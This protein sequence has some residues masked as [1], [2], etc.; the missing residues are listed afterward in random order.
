MVSGSNVI[1]TSSK[2][3]FIPTLTYKGRNIE[4]RNCTV[5]LQ[6]DEFIFKASGSDMYFGYIGSTD[7]FFSNAYG[8]LYEVLNNK[9]I[10]FTLSN[11]IFNKNYIVKYD[12]NKK[13][14]GYQQFNSNTGTITFANDVK[15]YSFRIGYGSAVSGTIYKTKV[16]VELGSTITTYEPHQD[17]EFPLDLPVENLLNLTDGT[18]THNEITANVN[19]GIITLNGTASGTSAIDIPIDITIKANQAYTLEANNL[20]VI[21]QG[22]T[23]ETYSCIRFI[24]SDADDATSDVRFNPINNYTTF[25]KTEET[26]YAYLRIRTEDGLTYNNF[27]IKPQLEQ[28]SKANAYTPYGTDPIELYKIGD[29]QDYFY[30]SGSKWYLHKEINTKIFDKTYT[31]RKHNSYNNAFFA[32]SNYLEDAD[33]SNFANINI[34]SDKFQGTTKLETEADGLDYRIN[35]A[36]NGTNNPRIH[37]TDINS[38]AEFNNWLKDNSFKVIY[39]LKEPI[40]TEIIDTTLISQLEAIYNAPLYKQT[41]ITQINNDLPI[42]LDITACKDNINGIKAFIRK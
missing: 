38:Q 28:G 25:Q 4:A 24:T 15:Y 41:N 35:L 39:K 27:I 17:K 42:I 5:S 33:V 40:N 34:Y 30:K 16:Q 18:Y 3:L 37:R 14:L 22:G 20:S 36:S 6:K 32:Y 23:G 13:I 9:T 21:G 31:F 1:N 29:Y 7:T 12:K 10:R 11:T 2:N 26:T 8:V 19:K